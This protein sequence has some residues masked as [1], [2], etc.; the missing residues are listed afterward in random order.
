MVLYSK[1]KS[2]QQVKTETVEEKKV[3]YSFLPLALFLLPFEQGVRH[4][5]FAPG[6]E[7]YVTGYA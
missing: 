2:P 5:H 4:L 1:Y 6:L 7:N 3:V